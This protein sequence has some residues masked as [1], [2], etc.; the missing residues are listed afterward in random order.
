MTFTSL[1]RALLQTVAI[2]ISSCLRTMKI[3]TCHFNMVAERAKD[4][5]G[6][7][8]RHGSDQQDLPTEAQHQS[9]GH[10]LRQ[11]RFRKACRTYYRNI[12]QKFRSKGFRGAVGSSSFP[13]KPISQI[14]HRE[15]FQLSLQAVMESN[16]WQQRFRSGLE[17][18][19]RLLW[20]AQRSTQIFSITT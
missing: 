20:I 5:D 14:P 8:E 7:S 6:L 12:E 16:I 3:Q 1:L 19:P 18:G 10:E 13:K 15:F 2:I 9:S 11:Q 17:A 4:P